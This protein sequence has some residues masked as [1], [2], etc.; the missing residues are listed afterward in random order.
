MATTQ[1]E[2]EMALEALDAAAA[3][4]AAAMALAAAA[5]AAEQSFPEDPYSIEME[6]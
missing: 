1:A 5:A 3:D 4:L 6:V 2:E